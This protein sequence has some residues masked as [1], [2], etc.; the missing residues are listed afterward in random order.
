MNS[1]KYCLFLVFVSFSLLP[2]CALATDSWQVFTVSSGLTDNHINAFAAFKSVM[3][4]GTNKGATIYDGRTASWQALKLPEKL[5]N[6]MIKD[7]AFDEHG[8]LWLAT[9]NGLI[10]I[11]GETTYVYTCDD[12][13]P[14][15]DIDRI[16]IQ[17]DKIYAGCFGGYVCHGFIPNS[18][19]TAFSPVNYTSSSIN[20]SVKIK[21][22]GIT[23]LGMISSSKGWISTKGEG[24]FEQIGPNSYPLKDANHQ[25]ESWINDFWVFYGPSRAT[26]IVSLSPQKINL[27]K[28]SNCIHDVKLPREDCWLNCLTVY[29]ENPDIYTNLKM[30]EMNEEEKTLFD[31]VE[32]RSLFIGTRNNGLWRYQK[33]IWTNYTSSSSSLPSDCINR[34]YLMGKKLVICTSAGLVIVALDS[35]QFDE[36]KDQGLGKVYAKTLFPFPPRYAH[37]VPFNQI[38]KGK[39]YWFTHMLGLSRWKSSN[40]PTRDTSVYSNSVNDR[41]E[42]LRDETDDFL[43]FDDA[44]DPLEDMPDV[45]LATEEV[46]TASLSGFWQLFTKSYL[47]SYDEEIAFDVYGTEIKDHDLF[48]MYSDEINSMAIDKATDDLWLIFENK[49]LCRLKMEFK[50]VE[51]DG[52]I[53]KREFPD[54]FFMEAYQPWAQGVE[55]ETVWFNQDKL[56][57][58]TKSDGFYI[59]KNPRKEIDERLNE[60]EPFEW[61]HYGIYEGLMASRVI[62]FTR[63]KS[64]EGEYLVI[65]HPEAISLMK[66]Q[67]FSKLSTGANREY[68]C[69]DAGDDGNLWIGSYGGLFRVTPDERLLSYSRTDAFFESNRITAVAALKSKSNRNTGVWVACDQLAD[70]TAL[71]DNFNGSDQPPMVITDAQGNKRVIEADIDGSSLHFFDGRTW[72]KWKVA[73]VKYIFIDGDYVWLSSNIRVRRLLAPR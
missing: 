38:C 35:H 33:G 12:G 16:Q 56:F 6:I 73:G 8:H 14:T 68:T 2:S 37:M 19:K 54:C 58:G 61:E 71:S 60:K 15:I 10:N 34:L 28:N 46:I 30:P 40:N 59:L 70:F 69:I 65:L 45:D 11:Q 64:K 47:Y 50:E 49:R 7:L 20:R 9:S 66:D 52:K 63:W 62:D 21:S 51:I 44:E 13:L 43:N 22:V 36:F 4:V 29:K 1:I 72:E 48:E 24:L 3:V 41:L 53:F 55:L 39:D 57:I 18:G 27:I 26:H 5:K 42:I 31:F 23:A 17:K 25:P 67:S 32:N